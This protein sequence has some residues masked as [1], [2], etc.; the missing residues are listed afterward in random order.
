VQVGSGSMVG[1]GAAE[2][3]GWVETAEVA[4]SSQVLCRWG[5]GWC[6]QVCRCSP[7]VQKTGTAAGIIPVA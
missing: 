5:T 6:R 2:L 3:P 4:F 1:T 7:V